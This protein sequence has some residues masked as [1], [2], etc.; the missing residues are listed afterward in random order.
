MQMKDGEGCPGVIFQN[1]EDAVQGCRGEKLPE[2]AGCSVP[3]S[4]SGDS[5]AN[6]G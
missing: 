2:K 4:P 3:F 6:G 1:P 5:L